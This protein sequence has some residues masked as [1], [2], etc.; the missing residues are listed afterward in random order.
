MKSLLERELARSLA[1]KTIRSAG[2][3]RSAP[4]I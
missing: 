4:V 2:S 3:G 1:Q